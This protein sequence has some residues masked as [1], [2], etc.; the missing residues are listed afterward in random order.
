MV[1]PSGMSLS[2]RVF[3]KC[4]IRL[5]PLGRQGIRLST[6]IDVWLIAAGSEGEVARH[7]AVAVSHLASLGYTINAQKSVLVPSQRATF[8]GVSL[9]SNTLRARL[10]KERIDSVLA[11]V[12]SFRLGRQ[13]TYKQCMQAVGLMA[14]AIHLIRLGRFYMRPAQRW[15]R[16]LR[17]PPTSA[18]AVHKGRWA[19]GVWNPTLQSAHIN[20]L[21]LLAVFLALKH[22][23]ARI[24]GCHVSIRTGNT[25]TR[26][27]IDK[28]GG[29]TSL[30]LNGLAR[31]LA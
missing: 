26:S 13:V 1:L 30:V 21:E 23:E 24:L 5:A 3:V 29:L 14:S 10:S 17:I 7:T 22:F 27:F 2:P 18:H 31:K 6:Y 11:C 8:L 15:L 28:Q 4:T 9:D 12:R 25:T 20:Y 16:A 19:R